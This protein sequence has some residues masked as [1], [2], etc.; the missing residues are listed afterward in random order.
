ML[1]G[2]FTIVKWNL[3]LVLSSALS[4]NPV[5]QLQETIEMVFATYYQYFMQGDGLPEDLDLGATIQ[6]PRFGA[7]Q[8]IFRR[9]TLQKI[10]GRGGMGV[11]AFGGLSCLPFPRAGN[12][13]RTM[14]DMVRLMRLTAPCAFSSASRRVLDLDTSVKIF[15]NSL[16]NR[17]ATCFLTC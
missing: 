6:I 10:I 13:M 17:S 15:P 7:G 2:R 4:L 5:R 3:P 9:Y 1:L 16:A 12:L 11:V 14:A 8:R